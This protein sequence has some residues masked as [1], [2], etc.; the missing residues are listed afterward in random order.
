MTRHRRTHWGGG[1]TVRRGAV[2]DEWA[3]GWP[4]CAVGSTRGLTGITI[5]LEP[6]LVDCRL[7][8]RTMRAA[9]LLGSTATEPAPARLQLLQ[10]LV[11][12]AQPRR[13]E[14]APAPRLRLIEGGR[15]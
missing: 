13:E 10:T 4:C 8:R 14:P 3:A 7:C 9:G 15:S 1:A 11:P 5:T 12:A 6:E 2:H